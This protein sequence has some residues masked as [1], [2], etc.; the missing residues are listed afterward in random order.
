MKGKPF[1]TN[2][3][4]RVEPDGALEDLK[5]ADVIL[6]APYLFGAHRYPEAIPELVP[7]LIHQHKQKVRIGA[8]C[9]AAFILAQTGL[10]DGRIATTNW[11]VSKTF[12]QT[13]PNVLVKPDRILTEDN[14]L[15]CTG[16]ATSQYHL[17]LHI[18]ERFGSKALV[19]A[20]SK[21]FLVDP[22]R[23]SQTPYI[24]AS[25]KKNHGDDKIAE[26]QRWMETSYQ[27]TLTIDAIAERV[28]LSSRHFKRRFKM[29]TDE[30]P[31]AYLHQIRI[32]VA[33]QKLEGTRKNIDEI[34]HLV[35][36]EDSGTFRR[37]FKRITS[38][39]PREYRDR[40]ST[41]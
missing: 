2:S 26:A 7:L 17:A 16:A 3:G 11:Q 25:F 40:F 33:K 19:R 37:L 21:V 39:S 13:F 5:D 41:L 23:V 24:I 1:I 32:E 14:G 34:T 28:G 10:L 18:I 38:L 6:I 4:I 15:I 35:G 29:A 31:I 12:I 36:Y 27:D 20:C 9:T 8:V 22:C 30:T